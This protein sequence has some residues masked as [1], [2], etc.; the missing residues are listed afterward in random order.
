L[1]RTPEKTYN[2]YIKINEA[3]QEA[4]AFGIENQGHLD[5]SLLSAEAR[6]ILSLIEHKFI[7]CNNLSTLSQAHDM[8]GIADIIYSAP[9]DELDTISPEQKQKNLK[10][11]ENAFNLAAMGQDVNELTDG[12]RVIRERK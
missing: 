8:T 12:I 11:F 3:I 2:T 4:C 5:Q 1:K 9:N 10:A 7:D 6:F